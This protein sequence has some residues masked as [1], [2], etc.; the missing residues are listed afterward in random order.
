[1]ER[2]LPALH[3]RMLGGERITYG[4]RP[5]LRQRSGTSRVMKLLL[6]LL[7]NSPAGITRNKLIED[8]YGREEVLDGANNLRVACYRLKKM[9]MNGGLPEHDYIVVKDGLYYFEAPAYIEVDVH[10]FRSLI[11]RADQESN[12]E[13]KIGLLRE[14]CEMYRGEFLKGLSGDEWVLLEG[15]RYK[16]M[17]AGALQEVCSY[18]KVQRDYEEI[19]RLCGAACEM[20][21]FDEWQVLRIDC[22]IAMNRYKEYEDTAKLFFEELGI[23]PSE[24]MLEQMKVLSG[25]LSRQPRD[26]HEIKGGL[27]EKP[28]ETGAYYCSLP[29]FRDGYRLVRRIMERNGQSIY[30]ML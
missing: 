30:L 7:Y 19:L 3:V 13:K 23:S 4:G 25:H 11:S 12:K 2:E 6:I 21:P 20:Y 26:I 14:A 28:A 10:I 9:L 16:D 29:S 24:R 18:L 22:Y 1:M 27:T 17:Y 5:I 15:M 8:L